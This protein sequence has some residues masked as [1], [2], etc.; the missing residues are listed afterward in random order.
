MFLVLVL[1]EPVRS[2]EPPSI[3]GI[4]GTKVPSANSD[5][6]REAIS[7]GASASVFFTACTAS[8]SLAVAI[9][10]RMRRSN[11][12]RLPASSAASFFF[13]AACASC[14]RLPALRQLSRMS[15]GTSNGAALQPSALRAPAISSAPSGEPC[16]D[17]LPA[18]VGGRKPI[19]VLQA[20]SL[21][22]FDV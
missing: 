6:V 22:L 13:Q 17:D 16:G 14:E 7:F 18:L 3:S 12:A 9:S 5:A 20:I 1:L 21:G 15:A 8:V 10:P 11:S 19:V 4:A 2:A